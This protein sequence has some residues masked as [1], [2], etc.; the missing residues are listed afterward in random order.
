MPRLRD[1]VRRCKAC[2]GRTCGR[3]RAAVPLGARLNRVRTDPT[4]RSESSTPSRC[5]RWSRA[6]CRVAESPRTLP[7]RRSRSN[8]C[9]SGCRVRRPD[10]TS[11]RRASGSSCRSGTA[12]DSTAG[13]R[14]TRRRAPCTPRRRGPG[15]GS[16]GR[17]TSSSSGR[18]S[19]SRRPERTVRR[20][21]EVGRPLRSTPWS[22]TASSR[23]TRRQWAGTSPR[24]AL[25]QT[26][27]R[28]ASRMHRPRRRCCS[29][30]T[31]C[32]TADRRSDTAAPPGLRPQLRPGAATPRASTVRSCRSTS[33][34]RCTPCSS[35][36]RP[37]SPRRM[38]RRCL[39]RR[40]LQRR[41]PRW[42]RR[43][44]PRRSPR[45]PRSRPRRARR[46]RHRC[47][48]TPARTRRRRPK[49]RPAQRWPVPPSRTARLL[50]SL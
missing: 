18:T 33:S 10:N 19:R 17:T 48:P 24:R 46:R 41:R 11:R 45:C 21:P 23:S 37:G 29:I 12:G 8:T 35:R 30:A 15:T 4:C 13:S 44:P 36:L 6:V 31:T 7:R 9:S 47:C 26:P 25:R 2:E 5:R 14:C 1:W 39:R 3:L 40:C 38:L 34:S 49:A 32:C 28:G 43:C 27:R 20:R 42:F 16:G 22:S 50:S